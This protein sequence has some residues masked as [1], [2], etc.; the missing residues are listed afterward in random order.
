MNR[1][2]LLHDAFNDDD[3]ASAQ[4]DVRRRISAA[5]LAHNDAVTADTLAIF[6]FGGGEGLDT[7]YSRRLG[8]LLVQLLAAAVR[9]GR[10]DARGGPAADLHRVVLERALPT[11]TL[12][13]FAYLVERTALDELALDQSIGATTEPW[14]VVAQI[15]RRASFDMLGAYAERAQLEPSGA[16]LVDGLTTLYS[17]PVFDAAL[18][19]AVDR[20]GRCGDP[21][22]IILFDID[23]LAD[24]NH[25]HG[26][27][28][29]DRVLERLGILIKA[30]FR[31]HDWVAR[32]SEDTIAVILS[33]T[34]AEDATVLAEAV[35]GT[36]QERLEFLDHRTEQPVRVTISAGVVN[37]SVRVGDVL[38][39]ER[40]MS[41]AETALMRAKQNGRNR[42]ER[43]DG[44]S[45][46]S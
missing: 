4:E 26:Y 13:T 32:Y 12:F 1:E 33:R 24:I 9:D 2:P 14:P 45:R 23:R 25:D 11:E 39:A 42:V 40:I 30:F 20:A 34:E 46:S 15:V 17:R 43:F 18:G 28:V 35:R 38:D 10:L 19:K 5:L 27:G 44:Y 3:G 22:S 7:D 8:N 29:G 6:P 36:V 21:T 31:Q 16:T 41:N 37:I